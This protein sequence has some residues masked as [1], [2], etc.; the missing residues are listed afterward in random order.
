M[1]PSRGRSLDRSEI[2]KSAGDMRTDSA[3]M[4]APRLSG[5]DLKSS[6]DLKIGVASHGPE[7]REAFSAHRRTFQTRRKEDP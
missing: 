6:I 5:D 2:S 7:K 1:L 4:A 3:E